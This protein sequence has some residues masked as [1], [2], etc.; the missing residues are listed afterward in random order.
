MAG[1]ALR[2]SPLTLGPVLTKPW[3]GGRLPSRLQFAGNNLAENGRF[4]NWLDESGF[5]QSLALPTS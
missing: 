2:D 4:I 5:L 3:P 1:E